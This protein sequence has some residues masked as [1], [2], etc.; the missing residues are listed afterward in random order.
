MHHD[1]GNLPYHDSF[2]I[3]PR[4]MNKYPHEVVHTWF[5]VVANHIHMDTSDFVGALCIAQFV[6]LK[7]FR[8]HPIIF[9]FLPLQE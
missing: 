5:F 8:P 7:R 3:A 6:S 1:K 9:N 4:H 2:W